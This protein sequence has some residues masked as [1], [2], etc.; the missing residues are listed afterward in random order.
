MHVSAT[1]S[2]CFHDKHPA[3][4]SRYAPWNAGQSHLKT[5]GHQILSK[6][7]D[8]GMPVPIWTC[9]LQDFTSATSVLHKEFDGLRQL[10]PHKPRLSPIWCSHIVIG[11][12]LLCRYWQEKGFAA[13][14]A[15]RILNLGALAFTI[16][17]ATF[18]LLIFDRHGLKAQCLLDDTCDMA[19]VAVK[20]PWSQET[21]LALLFKLIFLGMFSFYWVYSA[22]S[23][24][25]E[26][27]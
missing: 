22:V 8:N 14:V 26:V 11:V 4:E 13:I 10:M 15:S 2:Q 27:W 19:T 17:M 9:S 1:V 5:S 16:V 3:R 24:S 6:R 21:P 20:H 12:K 25:I 7:V 18:L 23:A